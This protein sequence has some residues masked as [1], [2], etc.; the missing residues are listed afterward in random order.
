M[1]DFNPLAVGGKNNGVIADNIAGAHG[2]KADGFAFAGAGLAF[3][4]IDGNFG[5]ISIEG[6][7]DD[8]AHA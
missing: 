8:F 7:S 5:E 3:A 4:A 1:G 6:I 2:G